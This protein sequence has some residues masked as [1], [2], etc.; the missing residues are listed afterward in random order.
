MIKVNQ[1]SKVHRGLQ[2]DQ[3]P[4]REVSILKN[5]PD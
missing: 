2:E 3:E 1:A 4:L 5:K